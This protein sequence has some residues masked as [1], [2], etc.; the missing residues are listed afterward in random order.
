MSGTELGVWQAASQAWSKVV[1]T[2]RERS[3]PRFGPR[4]V[5]RD[6]VSPWS[7]S[8]IAR[9]ASIATLAR[10]P[11]L[12]GVVI[13][14]GTPQGYEG[15]E[16]QSTNA[17]PRSMREAAAFGYDEKT[18]LAFFRETGYDP[19]DLTSEDLEYDV[20]T[21]TPTFPRY[22]NR[23]LAL[24]REAYERWVAFRGGANRSA[25][26]GLRS[27]LGSIPVLVELRR[28]SGAQP[29][30]ADA[31]LVPWE[32][33]QPAPGL[34]GD[35]P[36]ESPDAI[37][38]VVAPPPSSPSSMAEFGQAVKILAPRKDVPC[39]FD[40]TRVPIA[41]FDEWLGRWLMRR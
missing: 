39:A 21:D 10:T 31:A 3:Y 27:R 32:M 5:D 33:G 6:L 14:D 11:G 2:M 35:S 26:A 9:F 7:P 20:Q 22:P 8:T 4:L 1:K 13:A 41:K 15:A 24:V 17:F 18:R 40:L 16:E 34:S 30:R 38:L 23:P 25:L 19:V 37:R 29:P 36:A 12:A 28:M